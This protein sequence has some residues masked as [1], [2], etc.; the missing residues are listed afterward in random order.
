[1]SEGAEQKLQGRRDNK[2]KEK[3]TLEGQRAQEVEVSRTQ[4][5]WNLLCLGFFSLRLSGTFSRH[6]DHKTL[7]IQMRK[8]PLRLWK[9]KWLRTRLF[10]S[11]ELAY[12]FQ[13]KKHYGHPTKKWHQI[14]WHVF[15][16]F[17]RVSMFDLLSLVIFPPSEHQCSP[18]VQPWP[19]SFR[20]RP[21]NDPLSELVRKR[22]YWRLNFNTWALAA[23]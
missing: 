10:S 13:S 14:R 1:M 20:G 23:C 21:A 18:T 6:T 15:G 9:K 17:I 12:S 3:E 7:H 16:F 2:G 22:R 8:I 5:E 4:P 19:P 11:S